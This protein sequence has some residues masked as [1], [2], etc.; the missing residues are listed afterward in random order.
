MLQQ[1]FQPVRLG[2]AHAAIKKQQVFT[3]RQ[4]GQAVAQHRHLFTWH[5]LDDP[6]ARLAQAIH[7]F[8]PGDQ[9]AIR[10]FLRSDQD[11][12]ER[13]PTVRQD[14]LDASLHIVHPA[15]SS[16]QYG[17][18][19][20]GVMPIAHA[21]VAWAGRFDRGSGVAPGMQVTKDRRLLL[22]GV[23]QARL[24]RDQQHFVHMADVGHAPRLDEAQNQVQLRGLA[25]SWVEAIQ[26]QQPVTAQQPVPRH[27]LRQTEQIVK[28]EAWTK[29][30]LQL[31]LSIAIQRIA[32]HRSAVWRRQKLQ[33][34]RLQ[35]RCH[36][37]IASPH[38]HQPVAGEAA[39]Q[40]IERFRPACRLNVDEAQFFAG[41][42][43][44]HLARA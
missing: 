8:Q 36:E 34:Q 27:D 22:P 1:V 44:R 3:I 38:Q 42:V 32:I 21:I 26:G 39:E 18:Q 31:P 12:I 29:G 6:H 5:R 19:R 30:A 20:L 37:F 10:I 23:G 16:Q 24:A 43:R 14:R 17:N 11:F 9:C 41:I 25:E 35:P 7:C 33:G 40:L 4:C 2:N 28:V 13:I 15:T